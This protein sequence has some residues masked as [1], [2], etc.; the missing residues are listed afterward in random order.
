M[1]TR[2]SLDTSRLSKA[3]NLQALENNCNF[4][5][6][7]AIGVKENIPNSSEVLAPLTDLLSPKRPY[8]MTLE[9]EK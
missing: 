6:R 9:R 4:F 5:S 8:K 1:E 3:P 2:L 7:F